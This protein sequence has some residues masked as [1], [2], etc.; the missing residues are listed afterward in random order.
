MSGALYVTM[1]HSPIHPAINLSIFTQ[2]TP[3]RHIVVI[4]SMQRGPLMQQTPVKEEDKQKQNIDATKTQP[5]INK[6]CSKL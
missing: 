5:L 6:F 3:Q 1:R 2:Q 4:T